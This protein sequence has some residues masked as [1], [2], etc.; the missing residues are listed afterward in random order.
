VAAELT[1]PVYSVRGDS[2]LKC[3][4]VLPDSAS[5]SEGRPRGARAPGLRARASGP[6]HPG[7]R[8]YAP[9]SGPLT[10]N[11]LLSPA[12]GHPH[13]DPDLRASGPPG[14]DPGPR[15]YAPQPG[16]CG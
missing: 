9:R 7:T 2:G 5:S 15:A 1:V 16:A 3:L 4:A 13:L 8:T 6:T 14:L 10:P 11:P 12:P